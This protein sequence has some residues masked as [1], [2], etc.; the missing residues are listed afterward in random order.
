MCCRH[1]SRKEITPTSSI[2]ILPDTFPDAIQIMAR[3]LL[4]YVEL[5]VS[6]WP[7]IG[8][9]VLVPAVYSLQ[10]GVQQFSNLSVLYTTAAV[11]VVLAE[12]YRNYL[13]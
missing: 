3:S 2:Y 13:V 6:P 11:K 12:R 7:C 9:A 8:T 4:S 10:L 5:V 1:I